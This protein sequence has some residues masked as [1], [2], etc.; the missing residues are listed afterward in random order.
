LT[1]LAAPIEVAI[2]TALRHNAVADP[3]RP[4][5]THA[6]ESGDVTLTRGELDRRTNRLARAYE[7]LGV[8]QNDL[9]TIALPN[10][11]EF[12]EAAIAVWKLGA[13][14]EP[15][16]AKLPPAELEA[17]IELANTPIVIGMREGTVAR[18]CVPV[19]FEPDPSFSDEP[20]D[21][22]VA[23][24]LKAPTSGGSTGRPKIILSGQRGVVQRGR[25]GAF[26]VPEESVVLIPG[27]LY[28]NAPFM[29]ASSGLFRGNHV[30]V[31]TRFDPVLTL[32]L[33]ERHRVTWMWVVPTMM[34][35]IM[36]VPEGER[37]AKD[38]SSLKTVW[39]GAA[40]C[41]PW[42]KEAW[43]HWLGGDVVWELYAGTEGRRRGG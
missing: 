18:T 41:P 12:F 1:D 9:V 23:E 13:T 34:S 20:F 26:S 10:G 7:Q 32:D 31:T 27:A 19:G 11:Y 6:T 17:I 38:V 15:V 40:P 4:A 30:I 42:V 33:I 29:F 36:R 24:S 2:S 25:T 8:K 39:H 21:E 5:L 43:I 16:S 14:P 28:H 3:D 35:R 22:R 37:L